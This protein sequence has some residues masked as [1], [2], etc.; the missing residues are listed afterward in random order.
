MIGHGSPR[1]DRNRG[2]GGKEPPPDA[3]SM[4]GTSSPSPVP[5]Q[6]K[7]DA[8]CIMVSPSLAYMQ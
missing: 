7:W 1:G 2:S 3:L 8:G 5:S 4:L 6:A